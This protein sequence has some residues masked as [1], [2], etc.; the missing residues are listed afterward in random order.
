MIQTKFTVPIRILYRKSSQNNPNQNKNQEIKP[1]NYTYPKK[2]VF[3]I[4]GYQE[5]VG[6]LIGAI[7]YKFFLKTAPIVFNFYSIH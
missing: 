6:T 1:K 3:L 7:F 4:F 5:N 2:M